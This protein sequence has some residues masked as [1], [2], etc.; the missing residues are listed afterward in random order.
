MA[1]TEET[2]PPQEIVAVGGITLP[3]LNNLYEILEDD[4]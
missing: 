4:E 3:S 2:E 1:D